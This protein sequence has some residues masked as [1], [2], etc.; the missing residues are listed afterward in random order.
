MRWQ[1]GV[2]AC[3][4]SAEL[5]NAPEHKREALLRQHV[6]AMINFTEQER[7]HF[8]GLIGKFLNGAKTESESFVHTDAHVRRPS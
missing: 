2:A 5:R 8:M 7:I 3:S 1:A 6:A 4:V